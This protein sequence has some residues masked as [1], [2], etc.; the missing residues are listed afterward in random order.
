M[1]H[2]FALQGPLRAL[3]PGKCSNPRTSPSA[4]RLARK[5]QVL[6]QVWIENHPCGGCGVGDTS[7]TSDSQWSQLHLG[8]T[9]RKCTDEAKATCG[10]SLYPRTD[11]VVITAV[12]SADG[13]RLL[14]GRKSSHP[15]G[16]YTCVAGF[17]SP[18]ETLEESCAREV[19]QLCCTCCH[20]LN[21]WA[22]SSGPGGDW[23]GCGPGQR[24][25]PQLPALAFCGT[26]HARVR[27]PGSGG[28]GS[29]W[30]R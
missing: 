3:G 27:V 15:H 2:H 6:W 14:L 8:G 19:R 18:G 7:P 20:S 22:M 16:V 10:R 5:P 9:K 28:Q 4:L 13:Q 11:P 17:I 21:L 23:G 30:W 1:P 25:V 24:A 26:T 12:A 29:H